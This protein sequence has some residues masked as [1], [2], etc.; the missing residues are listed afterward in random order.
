MLE[1]P[2]AS[3]LVLPRS[4]VALVVGVPVAYGA[5]RCSVCSRRRVIARRWLTR[6]QPDSGVAAGPQGSRPGVLHGRS[7]QAIS[8]GAEM[9]AGENRREVGVLESAVGIVATWAGVVR[10]VAIHRP[11][12]LLLSAVESDQ[13]RP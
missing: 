1:D 7:S 12:Q 3:P 4:T 6:E 10:V 5:R 11:V 8:T 9:P 13:R 2:V